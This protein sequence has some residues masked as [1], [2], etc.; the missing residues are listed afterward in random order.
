MV[1]CR[2][3]YQFTHSRPIDLDPQKQQTQSDLRVLYSAISPF[4]D[5]GKRR[6]ADFMNLIQQENNKT[7]PQN[8]SIKQKKISQES[9]SAKEVRSKAWIG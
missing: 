5:L 4:T 9:N 7:E 2:S 8:C 3:F 6:Q 1:S